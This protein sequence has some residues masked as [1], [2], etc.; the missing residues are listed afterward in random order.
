MNRAVAD[1]YGS[2]NTRLHFPMRKAAKDKQLDC[3]IPLIPSISIIHT[4]FSICVN[5]TWHHNITLQ[6]KYLFIRLRGARYYKHGSHDPTLRAYK[7]KHM[8]KLNMSEYRHLQ[9]KK[10]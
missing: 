3:W 10:A 4:I 6:L 5:T 2:R 7:S 9:M 1:Y 8:R